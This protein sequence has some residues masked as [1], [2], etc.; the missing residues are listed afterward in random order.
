MVV[1]TL[2]CQQPSWT[3]AGDSS[4]GSSQGLSRPCAVKP[5]PMRLRRPWDLG[6]TA[7]LTE[8]VRRK[9]R[10]C[11]GSG[12][13]DLWW[14]QPEGPLPFR[15]CPYAQERVRGQLAPCQLN[16]V[17]RVPCSIVPTGTSRNVP[18]MGCAPLESGCFFRASLAR[19]WSQRPVGGGT[20]CRREAAGMDTVIPSAGSPEH[21]WGLSPRAVSEGAVRTR[22][23]TRVAKRLAELF[24]ISYGPRTLS[25]SSYVGPG[26]PCLEARGAMAPSPL[27]LRLLGTEERPITRSQRERCAVHLLTGGGPDRAN[28][29][30]EGVWRTVGPPRP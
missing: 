21:P 6:L 17:L 2:V 18:W 16:A 11:N 22:H 9:P 24:P 30:E 13:T 14:V 1:R 27:R 25:C 28:R 19:R 26:D 23:R 15:F 10:C 8:G 29:R 20:A 5:A 3:V 7:S 12:E 4:P